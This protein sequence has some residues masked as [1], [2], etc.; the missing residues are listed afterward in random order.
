MSLE[1]KVNIGTA[2]WAMLG[3]IIF[4][5]LGE[6]D[7]ADLISKIAAVQWSEIL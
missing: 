3:V 7:L 4:M 1:V 6:P 5:H 2:F